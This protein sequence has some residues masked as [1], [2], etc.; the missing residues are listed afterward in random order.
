MCMYQESA[1]AC[2]CIGKTAVLKSAGRGR[3]YMS[4]TLTP[5]QITKFTVNEFLY[6]VARG[7]HCRFDRK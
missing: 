2:A 3:D 4:E 6:K 1:C 5:D 7:R